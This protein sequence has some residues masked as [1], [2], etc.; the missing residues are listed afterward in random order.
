[1]PPTGQGHFNSEYSHYLGIVGIV[2]WRYTVGSGLRLGLRGDDGQSSGDAGGATAFETA[3]S[4]TKG[5]TAFETTL[6]V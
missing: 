1:M 5:G 4:Y 2:G 3:T 6:G